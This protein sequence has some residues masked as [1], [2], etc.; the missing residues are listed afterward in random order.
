MLIFCFVFWEEEVQTYAGVGEIF[1]AHDF[2]DACRQCYW[3]ERVQ[4]YAALYRRAFGC[5]GGVGASF[6][7]VHVAVG[8]VSAAAVYRNRSYNAHDNAESSSVGV[9][10]LVVG[11]AVLT[12]RQQRSAFFRCVA[13]VLCCVEVGVQVHNPSYASEKLRKRKSEIHFRCVCESEHEGFGELAFEPECILLLV[14]FAESECSV[15]A[16]LLP[17]AICCY[18][19]D[20]V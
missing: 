6:V 11:C 1:V 8:A 18:G 5:A 19:V 15:D 7:F 17:A 2:D 10:A 9:A 20:L 16:F 14:A 12:L 3:L 13:K 4:H